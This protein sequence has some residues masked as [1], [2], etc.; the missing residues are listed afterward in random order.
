MKIRDGY[1]YETRNGLKVTI[2]KGDKMLVGVVPEV[3]IVFYAE[4]G[5]VYQMNKGRINKYDLI[6]ELGKVGTIEL[7]F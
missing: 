2:V 4:N 6:K 5:A 3:G 7:D 1:V